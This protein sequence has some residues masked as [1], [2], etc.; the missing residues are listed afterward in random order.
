MVGSAETILISASF[1]EHSQ[2]VKV[3]VKLEF[4]LGLRVKYVLA[5]FAEA[6]PSRMHGSMVSQ[7]FVV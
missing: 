2:A 1:R 4:R 7:G 5:F 3:R 6:R